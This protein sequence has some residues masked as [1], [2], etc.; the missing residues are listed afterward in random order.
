MQARSSQPSKQVKQPAK[1][2]KQ[3]TWLAASLHPFAQSS[4]MAFSEKIFVFEAGA[5][6]A[7]NWMLNQRVGGAAFNQTISKAG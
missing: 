4:F 5:A 6:T 7:E 2:D 1:K 3:A